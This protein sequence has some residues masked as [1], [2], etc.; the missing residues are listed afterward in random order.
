MLI[1]YIVLFVF[2]FTMFLLAAY[3]LNK[4]H[5]V[6]SIIQADSILRPELAAI[7]KRLTPAGNDLMKARVNAFV[8][9]LVDPGEAPVRRASMY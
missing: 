6:L 2:T 7:I 1:A 9:A 8:S 4:M 5:D 3:F